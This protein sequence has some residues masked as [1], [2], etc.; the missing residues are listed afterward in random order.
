MVEYTSQID[1][2]FGA[3]ADPTRRDIIE[4]TSYQAL[5]VNQIAIEYEM[6]IAAISK[7]LKVLDEANL[8][9]RRKDGRYVY[10]SAQVAPLLEVETYLHQFVEPSISKE[11]ERDA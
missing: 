2:I 6:S 10:V 4:R 11:G 1:L 7:H 9:T 5:T 8:I 3:L